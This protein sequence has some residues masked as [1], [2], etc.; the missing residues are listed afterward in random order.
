MTRRK[1]FTYLHIGGSRDGEIIKTNN[2][3]KVLYNIPTP[4]PSNKLM[5]KK[6]STIYVDI[7][8]EV[9]RQE[10]IHSEGKFYYY[11]LLDT[12]SSSKG[13]EMLLNNY[14]GVFD[15]LKKETP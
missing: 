7:K 2:E 14:T 13:I 4:I 3:R 5:S 11:Y 8:R 1:E 10:A 12:M 15:K 6:I 9:Y